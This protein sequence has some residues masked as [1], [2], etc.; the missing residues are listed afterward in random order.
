M[1]KEINYKLSRTTLFKEISTDKGMTYD[2]E[3]ID[4]LC[5]EID[6][7]LFL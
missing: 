3:G 2:H 5:W 1:V 7:Y 6:L 4:V